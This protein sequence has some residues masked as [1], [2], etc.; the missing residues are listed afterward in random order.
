MNPNERPDKLDHPAVPKVLRAYSQANVWLYRVTK[1]WLGNKWRIGAAFPWGVE[2]LL[3]TTTGRKTGQP[4]TTP[5]IYLQDGDEWAVVASQGGLP[6]HPQWYLNLSANSDVEIQL[7]GERF[8]ATARTANPEERV[9]LWGPLVAHYGDFATYQ[10]WTER[11]IP[12][13][14]LSR[15]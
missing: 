5:L 15:R 2:V 13:V 1:G 9:R 3:L 11:E 12:V 4:R 6:R 8:A 10:A 7:G 14:I